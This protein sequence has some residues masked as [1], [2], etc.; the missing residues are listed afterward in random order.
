[1]TPHVP[2]LKA[3]AWLISSIAPGMLISRQAPPLSLTSEDVPSFHARVFLLEK[4]THMTSVLE[5]G[6]LAVLDHASA[7]H[8]P[9]KSSGRHRQPGK[10][11]QSKTRQCLICLFYS[12]ILP[13]CIPC[14]TPR[15]NGQNYTPA[16][17]LTSFINDILIHHATPRTSAIHRKYTNHLAYSQASTHGAFPTRELIPMN[18]PSPNLHDYQPCTSQPKLLISRRTCPCP[19]FHKLAQGRGFGM[20]LL[21]SNA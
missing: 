16:Y 15:S 18:M 13:R 11:R 21:V 4:Q 20:Y 10:A 12:R 19:L 6:F 17:S 1:M 2:R 7:S 14:D 9:F 8:L 5:L 3:R